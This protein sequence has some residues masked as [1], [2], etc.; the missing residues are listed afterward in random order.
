MLFIPA[1]DLIDGRCVR[2]AQGDFGQKTQ[3]NRDPAETARS[4]QDEGARYLHVVDL[5]AARDPKRNNRITIRR[6][7]E[8]VDIPVEVGG[9]IRDW[10]TLAAL[11]DLGVARVILGTVIVKDQNL[12][13]ELVT[14][15]GSR[16]VAGI[17][18]RNGIVQISGWVEQGSVTALELGMRVREM[19]FS[20]VIYTDV[21]RDGTL[22]GPNL[23]GIRTMAEQTGLPLVAAGGISNIQ[24]LKLV[25]AL[26]D[27][28]VTGV[29]SGKA[30]HEGKFTVREACKVLQADA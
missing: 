3:Y 26:E 16:L 8:A 25:K 2:L 4:F 19:G 9:G 23:Q 30:L 28:G 20:L 27:A 24:D 29:I 15:Y 10:N 14:R 13:E 6:I 18:A 12:V 1:I 11:L 22:Q 7:I 21:S 17:D 5:D